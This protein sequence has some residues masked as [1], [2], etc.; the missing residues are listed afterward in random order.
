M[1]RANPVGTPSQTGVPRT[2]MPTRAQP[3]RSQPTPGNRPEH[4]GN[5]PI[6]K[7]SNKNRLR[8]NIK[9][10]SINMNGAAAP[11][12]NMNYMAKWG[13]VSKVIHN[14]KIA[15]LAIQ[16]THLDQSMTERIQTMLQKNF[17]VI[18]LAHPKNPCAKAGVVFVINKQLI[19]PDEIETHE[20]IPG[21]ALILRIKW[22]KMCNT[23]ILNIY[24]PNKRNAHPRF[25]ATTLTGRHTKRI[26]IPDFT[27]GDFNVTEDAINRMPPRL[28]DEDAI[29]ALRDVKQEWDIRDSW[30][31]ANPTEK[32]FTY[33]AQ[34]HNDHIQARLDRIYIAKRTEPYTFDWEVKETAIPT[35]HTMVTVKYA[36]KDAPYIG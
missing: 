25:W 22:L 2:P 6:N 18:V 27:L 21:K 9:I 5:Q 31:W 28:D 8:A 4:L 1:I 35:N 20:L 24:A 11:S 13:R 10:A 32:A 14:E 30:R 15:I 23:T 19:E 12:E 33:G 36:P 16:E 34:T 29:S 7:N 26:P 3:E 17:E